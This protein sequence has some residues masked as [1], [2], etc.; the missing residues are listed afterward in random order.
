MCKGRN[1]LLVFFSIV[2]YVGFVS[3]LFNFSG[4][5]KKHPKWPQKPLCNM[6]GFYQDT[7]LKEIPQLE[8]ASK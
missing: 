1:L 4:E 7:S 6:F 3:R 2:V 5:K 8:N